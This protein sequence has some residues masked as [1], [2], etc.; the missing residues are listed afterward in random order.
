MLIF[1]DFG[2]FAQCSAGPAVAPE[3]G[4][5]P[6]EKPAYLAGFFAKIPSWVHDT[7]SL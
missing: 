7:T 5:S 2:A 4:K 6:N 1:E 3:R